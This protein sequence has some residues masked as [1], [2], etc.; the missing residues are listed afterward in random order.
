MNQI[1]WLT[2]FVAIFATLMRSP[3]AIAINSASNSANNMAIQQLLVDE[4]NR[5]GI[6]PALAL[7]MAEVESNFN[8]KALSKAGAKGVMQIMP[9]TAQKVFGI[10]SEQLYDE[11]I[12]IHLGIRFIKQ[13]LTRYN[14]RLDIA[15]SH[16]NG[17]SAVQ[18]KWGRLRVIP[19]TKR[20]V[21]KVLS[22]REKYNYKAYQLSIG[23]YHSALTTTNH[24]TKPK[25][26]YLAATAE[27]SLY[28]KVE[29]LR[30]LRLHNIMRNTQGKSSAVN[31]TPHVYT[32]ITQKNKV[33][34]IQ[35]T[36]FP[37]S[38]KR[39]KV[40]SWEAIYN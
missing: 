36:L 12:N 33:K 16:Y 26:H 20:Y 13:L 9:A 6:D 14:Q 1:K 19:A 32:S 5:Q 39:K 8:P 38:E 3:V 10:S 28:Q 4:A 25:K 15:L 23:D 7:A 35:K 34:N 17:G 37:L 40:L 22:A 31:K 2:L 27:Q 30:T 18:D 29:K 11:K 21:N 24:I